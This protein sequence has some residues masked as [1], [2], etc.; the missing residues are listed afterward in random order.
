MSRNFVNPPAL[1]VVFEE[2]DPEFD[3]LVATRNGGGGFHIHP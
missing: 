3:D 1:T 2:A